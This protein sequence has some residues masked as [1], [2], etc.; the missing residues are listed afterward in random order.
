MAFLG[1]VAFLPKFVLFHISLKLPRV[2]KPLQHPIP[3]AFGLLLD[4]FHDALRGKL[5]HIP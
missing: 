1:L 5:L 4:F 3:S 2:S